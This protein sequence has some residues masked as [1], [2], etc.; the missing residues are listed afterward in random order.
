MLSMFR[1]FGAT[2]VSK[3]LLLLLAVSFGAWGIGGY[4]VAST[5]A[6]ALTVNGEDVSP[7]MLDQV[8]KQRVASIAQLLG[9][10][11]TKEQLEQARVPEQVVQEVIFRTALRQAATKLGLAPATKQLQ[12]E[13]AGIRFFHDERGQFDAARYRAV[14]QQMGK[15]PEQFEHDLGQDLIVRQLATLAAVQ[16]P[17]AGVIAPL[18]ALEDATVMLDVATFSPAMLGTLPEPSEAVV[19]K[20]FADNQEVYTRPETRDLTV[21]RL[22]RA[23]VAKTITVPEKD[24]RAEYDANAEAYSVPEKRVVR[25]ILTDSRE[26]AEALRTKVKTVD[27]FINVANSDSKDPG[28]QGQG[29]LLGTIGQKD[30]VAPFAKAAF[31]LPVGQVSAPVQSQFGWHLIWVEKVEPGHTKSFDDVKQAIA[32]DLQSAQAEDVLIRLAGQ[33][34]EKVAGGEPLDKIA[35]ELGL[36]AQRYSMVDARNEAV[37]P[38][39]LEAGFALQQGEVSAPIT[40]KDGGSAYVQATE[41]QAAKVPPLAEVRARVVKDWKQTQAQVRLQQAADSVAQAAKAPGSGD[42]AGTVEKL[43]L[44]GVTVSKVEMKGLAQAPEW[45]Q[46]RLVSL[47]PLPVGAMLPTPVRDG[48]TWRVVRLTGRTLAKPDAKELEMLAHS[49]GGRLQGDVEQLLMQHLGS[50]AKVVLHQERLKQ[51]FGREVGSAE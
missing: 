21:L 51:L 8:Y 14:L 44:S 15:T 29:G 2:K 36:K 1:R 39:E 45:L 20:F 40:L 28:N 30:V 41:V 43:G 22:S 31:A 24:V 33:V 27:D 26:S 23:D 9:T 50:S 17:A 49:Y 10:Q 38:T 46:P 42:L 19:A 32:E 12:E 18:A 35:G 37:P 48:D 11:P 16:A 4:L 7:S 3:A 5:G 13:I 25:H 6:A 47:F 34:D